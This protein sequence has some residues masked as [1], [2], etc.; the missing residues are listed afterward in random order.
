MMQTA[1]SVGGLLREW[2]QRRRLSQLDLAG[3]AEISTRHLSFVE[4]GRAQPSRE[5]VLHLADRLDVPL[6]TFSLAPCWDDRQ[7]FYGLF[8][9]ES[10]EKPGFSESRA[11]RLDN[12]SDLEA[13]LSEKPGFDLAP[14]VDEELQRANI[15]YAAKRSSGRLGP[16]QMRFL[17][18][19]EWGR[20]QKARLDRS[21]GSAEQYKHPCL[22][23]EG[24]GLSVEC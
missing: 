1:Q 5:M 16:V 23:P 7:P 18:V 6:G 24:L 8:V 22:I 4:S 14:V 13:R 17:P 11:S 2:R 3:E 9:E 21:G 15:E 20:W 19:G 10:D 12:R